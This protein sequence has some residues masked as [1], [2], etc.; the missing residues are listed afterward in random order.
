MAR[1]AFGITT[2]AITWEK[3]KS[4]IEVDAAGM[5]TISVEGAVNS[6]NVGLEAALNLIPSTL[7]ASSS[8]PIGATTTYAGA[9]ISTKSAFWEGGTWQVSASYIKGEAQTA[10]FPDGTDESSN[11]RYTRQIVV[12]NEPIMTHPV[13]MKF[14][15]AEKNKLANL[16]DGGTQ[17]NPNYDPEK[18]SQNYEFG[19]L[20]VDSGKYDV[21]VTF[22][23]EAVTAGNLEGSPLDWARLIKGGILTY[24]RKSIRHTRETARN[25][26]A[27]NVEYRRVGTIVATPEGAPELADGYDWMLTGIIDSSANNDSWTTVYEFDASGQGGYLGILY[28]GGSGV[29]QPD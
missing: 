13:A 3:E 20:N 2:S 9:K 1:N 28:E 5:A 10:E 4:Q 16:I 17:P 26:P 22:S 12:V 19:A 8:G 27:P 14:P 21:R 6:S 11:D 24:Q 29:I 23:D 7:P 15:V 25:A 18:E